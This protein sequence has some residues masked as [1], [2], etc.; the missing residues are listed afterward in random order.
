M[1]PRSIRTTAPCIVL[2]AIAGGTSSVHAGGASFQGLGDLPGGVFASTDPR[3]CADGSVVVGWSRS[4][5]GIE[6]FSWTSVGGMVGLGDQPGG[7]FN[8]FA[9]AA[10][11]DLILLASLG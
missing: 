9:R 1:Q 2:A 11:A 3:V 8:S 5:S 4:G 10:S 7:A 6:A